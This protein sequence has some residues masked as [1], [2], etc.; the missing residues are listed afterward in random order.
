VVDKLA[1]SVIDVE[2]RASEAVDSLN[3]F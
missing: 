2:L 1:V 3:T